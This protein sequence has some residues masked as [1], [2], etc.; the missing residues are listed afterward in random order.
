[1]IRTRK[2][3]TAYTMNSPVVVAVCRQCQSLAPAATAG[4]SS[5]P[6]GRHAEELDW[7]QKAYIHCRL[8]T[9]EQCMTVCM[10]SVLSGKQRRKPERKKKNR[11]KEKYKSRD[12]PDAPSQAHTQS[13]RKMYSNADT[14]N[15]QRVPTFGFVF[16]LF[17]FF[18]PLKVAERCT[19][20]RKWLIFREQQ[21]GP[22]FGFCLRY[23]MHVFFPENISLRVNFIANSF[24]YNFSC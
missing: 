1:M 19:P 16:G 2:T 10:C 23:S 24:W 20:M 14:A 17:F 8:R 9:D 5:T 13:C 15:I 4:Q 7:L 6:H 22:T 12:L 11:Q 21:K 3:C 18:E